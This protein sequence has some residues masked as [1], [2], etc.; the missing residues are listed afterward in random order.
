VASDGRRASAYAA[1]VAVLIDPPRWPAHGTTFSHLVSDSSLAE[2][3]VFAERAGIRR[4]AFDLDH[5]D[6]PAERYDDLVRR[7]AHPVT[8]GEL[9]RRLRA[10]GLRVR[11]RER[12]EHIRFVLG[13]RWPVGVSHA[14]R[15]E[16]LERWS[17]PHRHYHGPAHLLAVLD[18]L[19]TLAAPVRPVRAVVLAGWFHDAVYDGVA[20]ADEEASAALASRLLV[21]QVPSAEIAEV[22]RLVRLTAG[23]DPAPHD[24]AGALLCD[25]DL[26]V[27]GG[28]PEAYGRYVVAVRQD[29][30]HVDDDA[31]RTGRS[32]V[33]RRL[34]A[35]DPL[36]RT[37][38]GR[39]LWAARAQ[40]NLHGEL[41]GLGR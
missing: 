11:S 39:Q 34:L 4:R 22:T 23:H 10:S 38:R 20:G 24:D 25:A 2:L 29:F 14:V 28:S 41:A 32:A 13:A 21:D 8:G 7:G 40:T 26:A 36:Y 3:H 5:Y 6:V 27:L 19:D 30:A 9:I 37:E 33:L 35:L 15:D 17:E 1:E 31:W 18:A 16:L 12:P